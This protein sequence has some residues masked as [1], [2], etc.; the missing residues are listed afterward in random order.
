MK[1]VVNNKDLAKAMNVESG[2]EIIIPS[3]GDVPLDRYWRD[4]IKDAEFDY[5]VTIVQD[6]IIPQPT[7]TKSKKETDNAIS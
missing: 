6:Q 7:V 3:D 4:R 5:C 2:V 1:I